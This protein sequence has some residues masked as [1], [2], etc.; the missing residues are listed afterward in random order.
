MV[1]SYLRA[2]LRNKFAHAQPRGDFP[3]LRDQRLSIGPGNA[4]NL[5]WQP[6][7]FSTDHVEQHPPAILMLGRVGDVLLSEMFGTDAVGIAFAE[8]KFFTVEKDEIDAVR[9]GQRRHRFAKFHQ[10]CD[11]AAAIV[12]SDEITAWVPRVAIR[13]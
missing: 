2:K 13:K 8:H 11:A 4:V 9:A 1:V 10:Q 6:E 5:L 7:V 3:D 12:R